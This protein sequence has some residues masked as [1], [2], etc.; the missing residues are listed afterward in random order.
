MLTDLTDISVGPEWSI[1]Q[2]LAQMDAS[3]RGIILVL[4]ED[5]RLL[6]TV[7]DGDMRRAVLAQSDLEQPISDLLASK[8]NSRF[9][10]PITAPL[11]AERA[12]LLDLLQE[13]RI[14]HLPLVDQD[15][16]VKA[17]VRMVDFVP[18]RDL[19]VQPVIM[20]GGQGLRMRPLTEDLPKPMLPVGGRPLLESILEQLTDAGIN[21]VNLITNFK[22]EVISNHFGDGNGFGVDIQYVEEGRPLGTAGSLNLL[23]TGNKPLLVINGDIITKVDYRAM[24]DFHNENNAGMT[25]AVKNQEFHL[26]YGVVETDGIRITSISEKPVI[27]P[28]VNAGIYLIDPELCRYIPEGQPYDMPDLIT[29][30]IKNGHNV[31]SFPI[32]EYWRDIGQPEDYE[33]VQQDSDNGLLR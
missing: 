3:R 6:G 17:L 30:I 28:F 19:S 13:Y 11:N 18:Q 15:Q 27:R 9:P 8:A 32:H 20:A 2:V 22:K 26:P 29:L 10:T 7:T 21:Q 31:V 1:H 12:T 25:V 4:H 5:G 14:Q 16:R 23:E 33:R 24:L